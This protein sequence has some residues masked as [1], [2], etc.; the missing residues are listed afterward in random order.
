MA[1]NS[2]LAIVALLALVACGKADPKIESELADA[3]ASQESPLGLGM[4][5][6]QA[7]CAAN[8]YA[9]SGLS[10]EYLQALANGTPTKVT[11]ADREE[12]DELTAKLAAECLG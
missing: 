10:A 5:P 9:E 7:K 12:L 3:F 4:P 2:V 8:L 6:E 1:K 11:K